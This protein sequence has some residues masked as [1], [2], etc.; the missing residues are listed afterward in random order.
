MK[1]NEMKLFMEYLSEQ[2]K[3]NQISKNITP[4]Y[5]TCK[6]CKTYIFEKRHHTHETVCQK[7]K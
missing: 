4:S 1:L 2:P 7:G 3:S 6:T 5:K